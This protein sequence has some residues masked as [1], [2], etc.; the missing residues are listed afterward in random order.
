MLLKSY[1][2]P[3]KYKNET[4]SSGKVIKKYIKINGSRQGL[5]IETLNQEKPLL[6]FLHGGPGFPVYPVVKAHG[7]QLEKYFDVCYWDQRGTGMSFDEKE[8]KKPLTL[9]QLL[10]DTIEVVHYLRE[11]YA[12]DKVFLLGHSWGSFLGTLAASKHPELFH[13][14]IGIGQIGSALESERESYDFIL[15]TAI[16]KRDSRAKQ[17]IEKVTLDHK[18][19]E[20]RS[21]GAIRSKFTNAYGGGTKRNGY[22][23]LE[24]LKHIL[25][26]PNYTF[27]ERLNILRGTNYA[28]QSLGEIIATTDLMERVP[29]LDLPVFILHGEHD[30]TTTWTQAN[31]FYESLE[32]PTKQMFTFRN[33]AHSPFIEEQERFYEIIEYE[34]LGTTMDIER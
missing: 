13:A 1:E 17:Q 15:N 3:L 5:I 14:Y 24:T 22:S 10:E 23:N 26:C 34:I 12:Q 32:A 29:S 8:M 19:Y 33:S 9:E 6:L 16:K 21:Y 30:Y 20:N 18:Y 31:R 28:W 27:K 11:T 7:L 25:A 2:K 4:N